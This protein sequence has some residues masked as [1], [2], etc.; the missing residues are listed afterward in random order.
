M[1]DTWETEEPSSVKSDKTSLGRGRLPIPRPR[2]GWSI[3]V[4]SGEWFT[5]PTV[6]PQQFGAHAYAG[7]AFAKVR[8]CPCGC[9]MLASS[10]GGPVDPFG[11]CPLNP[12]VQL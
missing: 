6:D 7:E 1:S 11:A 3:W 5:A 2:P 4:E 12:M 8:D 9:W 10:S